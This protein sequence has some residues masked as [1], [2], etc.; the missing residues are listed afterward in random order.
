MVA[1]VL[2][3][4]TLRLE[5]NPALYNAIKNHKEIIVLYIKDNDIKQKTL[6]NVYQN[7]NIPIV[8][9]SDWF[10]QESLNSLSKSITLNYKEGT[11]EEILKDIINKH[12]VSNIYINTIYEPYHLENYKHLIKV[13]SNVKINFYNANLLHNPKDE[14]NQQG[15][16]YKIF[17][18]FY[19]HLLTR[20]QLSQPLKY[21]AQ[22]NNFLSISPYIYKEIK[23]NS[24][25]KNCW[26]PSEEHANKVIVKFILEKITQYN[27]HRD[28]PSIKG[29]SN[30][31]PYLRYGLISPKQILWQ[32][33]QLIS[34]EDNGAITFIK[35]VIWR[36]FA[37]YILYHTPS[38]TNTSYKEIYKDFPW[39]ESTKNLKA[40]LNGN[41][42]YPIIDAGIKELLKTGTMHNR[43]RMVVASFLIKNLHYPWQT[44]A[45][46][47]AE[48]LVDFDLA[49]NS[50]SWQW[51]AGCGFDAAPYFR[52]FN[53]M[54]Q[55]EKFDPNGEY[56][57][58]FI[59]ELQTQTKKQ[60]HLPQ[61]YS[62]NIQHIIDFKESRDFLLNNIKQLNL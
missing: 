56:I 62:N 20:I 13:L 8:S 6:N 32:L 53:P 35:E 29:T 41:T 3:E 18:A 50:F 55:S 7:A 10:L 30:I 28:I 48:H 52:I 16:F 36:E 43:V 5:D 24:Y 15:G 51:V 38:I 14:L 60:I 12:S 26:V 2:L 22:N 45:Q 57:K 46:F 47:F 33:N 37:Y 17:T 42:G 9:N 40:W 1:I 11:K 25:I 19:K 54:L 27:N 31:S 49:I 39:E 59:P 4:N 58:T 23:E 21:S 61:K 44:G 34:P